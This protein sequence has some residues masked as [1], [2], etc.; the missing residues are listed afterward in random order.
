MTNNRALEVAM[1]RYEILA[2]LL[3]LGGERG[4]LKSAIERLSKELH[5]HPYLGIKK[6][7]P[8][9]IEEWLTRYRRGG[10]DGLK[11]IVRRDKGKSRKI[12]DEL[13]DAIEAIVLAHPELDGPGL[14]A[15]LH[16]ELPDRVGEFPSL[17]TVYRFLEAHGLVIGVSTSA[18]RDHRAYAFDLAGDCWQADVM[19]G[20][21]IAM[22]DG[23]RHKTYLI[24]ILDDAT[25]LI[26]HAQF[27]FDQ[28]LPSLRDCLK[29]ALLKRGV[30]ARLYMDNGQIFRSRMI[31][32]L[33]AR[34]GIHL[35]HSRPYRPQGRA[36][37]ERWFR[38]VRRAFLARLDLAALASI[39]ELN[40]LLFAWVEAS[41]HVHPHRGLERRTPLDCWVE[42]SGGIRPLPREVDLD[43]LFFEEV[44]R[45]IA[46]DGTFS[47]R[48]KRYEAG[49]PWIGAK[50]T[51]RF[52]PFDRRRLFLLQ[53][54][55]SLLE[56]YPVDLRANRYVRRGT[57]ELHRPKA[58]RVLELK[59]L[60]QLADRA[61]PLKDSEAA[62]G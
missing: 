44:T 43:E 37:L 21:A 24:A 27:Y 47:V 51:V 2:P 3:T 25:R 59:S 15:E 55:G 61:L 17:S 18:A 62:H 28:Q 11:D 20:P 38:R 42:K 35:L 14:M 49:A 29:Q 36:K 12:D 13:A 41:Y 1:W 9:T 26:A 19:Y 30:P 46:K 45:R 31:L 16:A 50:A 5:R 53:L 39:E 54:D 7:A 6:L 34:L 60:K 33:C 56:V 57:E 23:S 8:R 48:G 52:D 22:P 40:R 58:K 4:S 10:L 32:L